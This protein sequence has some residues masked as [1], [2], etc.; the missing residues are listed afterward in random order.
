M[1]I[2]QEVKLSP[3]ASQRHISHPKSKRKSSKR[4]NI[5]SAAA[6]RLPE[7]PLLPLNVPGNPE[8]DQSFS[9][10]AISASLVSVSPTS[11]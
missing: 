2:V 7:N 8:T 10:S 5:T 3:T 11:P 6:A 1:F 9:E 4:D